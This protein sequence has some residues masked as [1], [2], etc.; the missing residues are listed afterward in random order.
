MTF[1][2][3]PCIYYGDEVGMQGGTDPYNRS[4]YPW[5]LENIELLN[6]FKKLTAL[7]TNNTVLIDGDWQIVYAQDDLL[8]YT[9]TLGGQC[10]L[11]ILNVG[12]QSAQ[13]G[14]HIPAQQLISMLDGAQHQVYDNKIDLH[15]EP[16]SGQL[17]K[18]L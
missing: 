1:P 13:A 17:Y 14:I 5:G 6:W 15:I 8:A 11:V 18:V 10:M 4:C 9:R 16:L 7:R 3:V 2:G 12:T